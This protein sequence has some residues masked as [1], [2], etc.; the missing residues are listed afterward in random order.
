M[1]FALKKNNFQVR[2][3]PVV[4]LILDGFGIGH[5]DAGDAIEQAHLT[6]IPARIKTAFGQGLYTEL[7]AH[8][9]WVGLPSL[10]DMGNSEVGHNALGSGQ[11]VAQGA[12]RVNQALQS[13][14]LFTTKNWQEVVVKTAAQG[15]T[16]HFLGLLS[17]GNVHSH[18]QQLFLLL[19]GAAKAQAKK[20]RV[21]VLLDGRDVPPDS[22]LIYIEQ[23]ENKLKELQAQGVDAR[24][25]S[26]GGRMHLTM[27]RYYSDWNI[28]RRGWL[29]H[30]LGKVVEEDITPQYPGYFK[31][32]TE[33]INCARQNFPDKLDQF[34]PAFVIVDSNGPIGTIEDGDAVINF[35]FRGDRAIE[36]SEAFE[37]EQVGFERERRPKVTYA[38]LLEYDE[39]A[40]L[41]SRYLVEPPSIKNVS[42]EYLCA[43]GLKSYAIAETHKYGHV[44][45]FWNGNRSGY[46]DAKLESYQEIKSLPNETIA[47]QPEMKINEVSK[48]LVQ[49]ILSGKFKYIRANFA[50]GDMVGHTGVLPSVIKAVQAVD[51]CTE[52]VIKATLKMGGVILVSADHGN[53]EQCLDKKG[54]PMT[55]HTLNPVPCF[56]VDAHYNNDYRFNFAPAGHGPGEELL[57]QNPGIANITA[58]IMNLLGYQAPEFYEPSLLKLK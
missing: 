24:I 51:R 21:H 44:T 42:G 35:N 58:T 49:A 16:I 15:G 38:G 22:G 46:I 40:H 54:K 3:G 17:D 45:Y 4:E 34:N 48:E 47:A 56:I 53:A 11:I 10:D 43:Q 52:E 19:E 33:A 41:P 30:V 6:H 12:K 18:I 8:G 28:V 2:P 37:K 1:A 7:K 29:A 9:P 13:G 36:I 25:A 26:G 20:I 31:S 27:D 23:L 39:Q 14:E 32:A 57:D 50:N 5:K 55:S